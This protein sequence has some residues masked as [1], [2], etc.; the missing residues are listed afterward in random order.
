VNDLSDAAG[1]KEAR[2]V[3]DFL[4]DQEARERLTY[5]TGRSA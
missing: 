4:R 2:I 1:A 5:E 3:I